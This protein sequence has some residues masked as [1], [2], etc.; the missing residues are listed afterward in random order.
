MLNRQTTNRGKGIGE[1]TFIG[2]LLFAK[3]FAMC[4][5]LKKEMLK[6]FLFFTN[7]TLNSVEYVFFKNDSLLKPSV[8]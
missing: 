2:P 5:T 1:L 6:S 7:N 3:I 4:S 8:I